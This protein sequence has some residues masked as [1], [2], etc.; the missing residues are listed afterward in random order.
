MEFLLS[1]VSKIVWYAEVYTLQTF[2]ILVPWHVRWGVYVL[3]AYF[4]F[5]MCVDLYYM[6]KAILLTAQ[7]MYRGISWLVTTILT[8]PFET[9][10]IVY[11]DIVLAPQRAYRDATVW[12]NDFLARWRAVGNEDRLNARARVNV[13]RVFRGRSP[14]SG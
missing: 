3:V 1:V 11:R 8:S 9:T 10:L 7:A 2:T 14:R 12:W 13:P 5:R 4:A 6:V